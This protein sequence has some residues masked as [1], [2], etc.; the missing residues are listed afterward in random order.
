MEQIKPNAD[1]TCS[2]ECP[3][4]PYRLEM[5]GK[6]NPDDACK[7]WSNG[8]WCGVAYQRLLEVARLF[9]E[10]VESDHF[11]ALDVSL[12]EKCGESLECLSCRMV[13]AYD[14]VRDL[15]EVSDE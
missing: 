1:G 7:K 10:F 6:W 3:I 14:A 4:H 13:R 12:R 8:G 2:R 15:V 9:V 11:Y 5:D